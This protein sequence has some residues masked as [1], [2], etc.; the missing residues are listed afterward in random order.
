MQFR[1]L[2]ADEIDVRIASNDGLLLLYKDARCD[3]NIL[4]ETVG[5]LNWQ[6][7]HGRD[8]ANCLVSIWDEDKKQW[9]TKEDTGT[10]S[11]AEKEK[12]LASDSFKRACFNWGIGRELYTAPVIFIGEINKHDKFEVAH[13]RM[14]NKVI[15]ELTI[16]KKNGHVVYKWAKTKG[17]E[18]NIPK[19]RTGEEAPAPTNIKENYPTQ[20]QSAPLGTGGYSDERFISE[21][22]S[23]R[24]FAIARGNAQVI[25]QI[26]SKYGYV[27]CKDTEIKR[28]DYENICREI[29]EQ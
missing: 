24:M 19:T 7:L 8:N 11:Y 20:P 23:R 10:E 29:S 17:V 13:I 21:A 9:I 5:A 18:Y 1:A 25:E 12:G 14:E 28:K 27:N 15:I 4:D 2:R 3:M 6:R 16:K 22:Q 26:K